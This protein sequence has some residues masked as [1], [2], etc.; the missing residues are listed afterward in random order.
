[1]RHKRYRKVMSAS[2]PPVVTLV[3]IYLFVENEPGRVPRIC[4]NDQIVLEDW[5][6][7]GQVGV[8]RK[9]KKPGKT[10]LLMRCRQLT[11]VSCIPKVA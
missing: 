2:Y 8:Q 7:N 4:Q 5:D 9:M 10:R 1:M 3:L 11:V 6:G